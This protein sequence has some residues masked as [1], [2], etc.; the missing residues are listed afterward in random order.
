MPVAARGG[1]ASG[2]TATTAKEEGRCQWGAVV[3]N[4]V[5]VSNPRGEGGELG[6]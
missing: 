2:S 6:R 3:T 4:G 5:G 1:G